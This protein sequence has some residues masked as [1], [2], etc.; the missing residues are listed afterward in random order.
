MAEDI[1][2]KLRELAKSVKAQTTVDLS[3]LEEVAARIESARSIK[4]SSRAGKG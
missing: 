3:K 1:K 4:S 2:A